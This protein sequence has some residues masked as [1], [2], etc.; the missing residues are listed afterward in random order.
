MGLRGVRIGCDAGPL[1]DPLRLHQLARA[2][3]TGH[4]KA[5]CRAV[6]E[7]GD[8]ATSRPIVLRW[9]GLGEDQEVKNGAVAR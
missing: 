8:R 6:W 2:L 1:A 5:E 3:D 9:H 4:L 7:L